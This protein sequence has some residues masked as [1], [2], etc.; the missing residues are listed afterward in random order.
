MIDFDIRESIVVTR[1]RPLTSGGQIKRAYIKKNGVSRYIRALPRRA[2]SLASMITN[3]NE[4]RPHGPA[5]VSH[6]HLP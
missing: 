1:A 5:I 2:D 6:A 4:R 3:I